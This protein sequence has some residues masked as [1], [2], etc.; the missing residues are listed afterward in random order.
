MS[1]NK[2][3]FIPQADDTVADIT[4][5][6]NTVLYTGDGSSSGQQVTGVGFKPDLV[7][8]KKHTTTG[9]HTWVDSVRG[10]N[11]RLFSDLDNAASTNAGFSLDDNG[12]TTTSASSQNQ[13]NA[14][15]VAWCFKA[16]GE[17]TATNTS[18]STQAANS[19]SIDGVLQPS[20]YTHATGVDN[21][22]YKASVN[23]QLG[24]SICYWEA[25]GTSKDKI[26]HFLGVKPDLII[27]KRVSDSSAW[28]IWSEGLNSNSH[29]LKFDDSAQVLASTIIE[30]I[31]ANYF[32]IGTGIHAVAR[33]WVSYAFVSKTG[34][35]DIGSFTGTGLAN[36][37]INTGFEPSFLLTK[38]ISPSGAN[39][40]IID[41][42]RDTNS[43]K[44]DYLKANTNAAEA[45]SST[46]V[47][48]NDDGFTFNGASFNTSG[49]THIYLA[50]A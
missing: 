47:T 50:I 36:K 38:R 20:G 30:D 41:N 19:I 48:F 24:F 12:F 34:L 29:R 5:H 7:W 16:G 10:E 33:D 45:T 28:T 21:Y 37:K 40:A 4:D 3:L 8:I 13:N 42:K 17:P 49:A 43:D 35:T 23:T 6:F 15:I 44:K 22:P 25:N 27:T 39:W 31:T 1:L 14:G 2:R 11:S 26:P 9:S 32:E 18:Q 46:G